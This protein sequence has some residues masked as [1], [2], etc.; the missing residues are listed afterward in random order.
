MFSQVQILQGGIIIQSGIVKRTII[1]S[2]KTRDKG[3]VFL[4]HSGF[5]FFTLIM[6]EREQRHLRALSLPNSIESLLE[7]SY[8]YIQHS[9]VSLTSFHLARKNE[10]TEI[11]CLKISKSLDI[12]L[13]YLVLSKEFS[14]LV[15]TQVPDLSHVFKRPCPYCLNSPHIYQNFMC[16]NNDLE[17]YYCHTYSEM[18]LFQCV[19]RTTLFQTFYQHIH[20]QYYKFRYQPPKIQTFILI[21]FCVV[22]N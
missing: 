9:I 11:L 17:F 22:T 8:I 16:K 1:G 19:Y 2:K 20:K 10:T 4:H 7:V 15:S 21:H 6:V 18:Y 14:T 12:M 13:S 3:F 5:N